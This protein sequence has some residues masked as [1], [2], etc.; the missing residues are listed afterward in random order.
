MKDVGTQM[1]PDHDPSLTC[2]STSSLVAD[3]GDVG[4]NRL[5]IIQSSFDQDDEGQTKGTTAQHGACND[6]AVER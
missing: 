5:F 6:R 2:S 3:G 1:Y 4:E